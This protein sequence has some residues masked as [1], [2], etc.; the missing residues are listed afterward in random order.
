MKDYTRGVWD[1]IVY[2]LDI[3]ESRPASAVVLDL[4]EIKARIEHDASK[5]FKARIKTL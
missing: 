5:N 1:T 2:V 3:L 4:R